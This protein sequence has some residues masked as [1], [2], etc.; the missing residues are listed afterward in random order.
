MAEDHTGSGGVMAG[1]GNVDL[2]AAKLSPKKA[3]AAAAPTPVQVPVN[4][5]QMETLAAGGTLPIPSPF[6]PPAPPA[7]EAPAPSYDPSIDFLKGQIGQQR[8]KL[9]AS[10]LE[11]Q[12]RRLLAFGSRELAS[13]VL[14]EN[15]PFLSQVS[16]DPT[17]STSWMAEANRRLRQLLSQTSENLG[18]NYGL[19]NSSG[20]TQQLSDI[21]RE[22]QV[23]VARESESVQD[24]L[25][26]YQT[27]LTQA[28]NEWQQRLFEA[29]RAAWQ[30]GAVNHGF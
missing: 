5:R 25:A 23:A 30:M 2:W 14:G 13:K 20:R 17:K 3:S 18:H 16:D 27:T 21:G 29:Q 9:Q 11:A 28:E 12:K 1:Y 10:T 7:P 15:D 22:H 6:A 26:G 4:Q 19:W 8:G 24:D